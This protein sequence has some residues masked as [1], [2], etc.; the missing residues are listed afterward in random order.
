MPTTPADDYYDYEARLEE[1]KRNASEGTILCLCNHDCI[2]DI[3]TA[4]VSL[5]FFIYNI[6]PIPRE[7]Y[8][9]PYASLF[10]TQATRVLDSVGST[11]LNL[12]LWLT[13]LMAAF[14]ALSLLFPLSDFTETLTKVRTAIIAIMV[15]IIYNVAME[16]LQSYVV[17]SLQKRE[18]DDDC[19]P[20]VITNFTYPDQYG[21][22]VYPE[23][24]NLASTTDIIGETTVDVQSALYVTLTII[25]IISLKRAKKQK[26]T[27]NKSK[28]AKKDNTTKMVLAMLLVFLATKAWG[29][30]TDFIYSSLPDNLIKEYINI[31][32]NNVSVLLAIVH[33]STHF[34]I[35]YFISTVYRSVVEEAWDKRKK[36]DSLFKK[37]KPS[38]Y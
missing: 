23:Q 3:I 30:I 22:N 17:I 16:G 19:E 7:G 34:F 18:D 13:I 33:S 32:L 21:L 10:E 36:K 28:A 8:C 15:V 1:V 11:A 2:S 25:L 4:T 37:V 27:V 9:V 6:F 38:T 31:Y 5:L 29:Y 24:S 26:T 12:S 14:R 35:C 20:Y